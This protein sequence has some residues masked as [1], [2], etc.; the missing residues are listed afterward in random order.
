[1]I[2]SDYNKKAFHLATEGKERG[3]IYV[4]PAFDMLQLLT[5]ENQ[6]TKENYYE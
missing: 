6:I 5:V 3:N 1:M 2:A 4:Y